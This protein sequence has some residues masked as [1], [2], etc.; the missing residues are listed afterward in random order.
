MQL[1]TS[2]SYDGWHLGDYMKSIIEK[3]KLGK[4]L[5]SDGAWGTSLQAKG[6]APGS[7]PEL[8]NVENR[9]AVF[10]I[11]KSYVDVGCD[12]IETNSFGGS[13]IKLA[14]YDLSDRAFELNYQATAISREAAGSEI[15]V[16]GSIGPT[17]IILM[18]GEISKDQLY[19]SFAEQAS[20]LVKGGADAI[21][22]ET[23]TDLEE[24]L[25]GVKATKENTSAVIICSFTF[26]KTI[27]NEFRT[28]MGFSPS[29]VAPVIIEAGVSVIGINCGSGID[30]M[31][32]I[33]KEFR[34]TNKDIPIIVQANAGIPI[35][36]GME[37]VYPE[38]PDE[39]ASKV[40]EL[41]DAGANIIGGCCGTTSEH[42]R[43]IAEAI[44]LKSKA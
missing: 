21:L 3:V 41:I 28:I 18:M 29:E 13:S 43:K 24:A 4:T 6:L 36:R 9:K 17:G 40:P 15:N 23:M 37:T 5:I 7:C 12:I 31:A 1:I 19:D 11:A 27:K 10:E 42:I 32:D 35:L 8:W 38:T 2:T 22:I 26:E 34:K 44:K 14:S 33:V 39:M 25:I 30:G 20:A 16:L